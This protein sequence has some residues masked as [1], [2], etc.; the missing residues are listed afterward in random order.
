MSSTL[1]S[2]DS[3][4]G[5]RLRQTVF[6]LWLATC[7]AHVLGYGP[8]TGTLWGAHTYAFFPL[9]VFIAGLGFLAFGGLPLLPGNAIARHWSS[10]VPRQALAIQQLSLRAKVL[11]GALISA[12]GLVILW[13]FRIRHLS[14]IRLSSSRIFPKEPGFIP[15]S[16]SPCGSIRTS[17]T[18]S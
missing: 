7:V 17:T 13:L 1:R 9:P 10:W 15:A 8:L 14:A 6:A 5:Q 4:I 16:R 18:T 2:Q 11:V 12:V 3:D